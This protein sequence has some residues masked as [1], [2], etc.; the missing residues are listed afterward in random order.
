MKNIAIS[1]PAGAS[2]QL[3]LRAGATSGQAI[4]VASEN[5]EVHYADAARAT[6]VTPQSPQAK[7]NSKAPTQNNPN[8]DLDVIL[9][10]LRKLKPNNR[11]ATIHSIKA[12][13]QFDE[14]LTDESASKILEDLCRRGSLTIAA[15]DKLQFR[16]T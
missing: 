10:R 7:S 5:V 11:T 15:N 8:R 9:K 16:N 14:P 1:V 3:V 4:I 13:F 12:M 6:A 2:V